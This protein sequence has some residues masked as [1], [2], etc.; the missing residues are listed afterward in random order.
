MA[1]LHEAVLGKHPATAQLAPYYPSVGGTRSVDDQIEAALKD[2]IPHLQGSMGYVIKTATVQTNE[3]GRG[4]IW[5]LPLAF[6][7]WE[8]VELLDLGAS[9]GLNLLAEQRCYQFVTA[10]GD[11][12]I[13]HLG[14]GEAE[15]LI[16]RTNGELDP[17]LTLGAN[18]QIPTVAT[19]RGVDLKPFLID[20]SFDELRLTSYVWADQTERI[21]R[22]QRALAILRKNKQAAA[23]VQL[24][25]VDLPHDLPPYLNQLPASNKPLVIFNTY[26]TQYFKDQRQALNE[27]VAL[28]AQSQNRPVLW[29]QWE[30]PLDWMETPREESEYGW[31]AF[32]ADFW[33]A[34]QHNHFLLGWVHPHGLQAR[35]LS[36]LNA[37]ADYWTN[38]SNQ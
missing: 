36:G 13:T 32:T 10:N 2:A 26:I 4:S 5:L 37:W 14:S 22:L 38:I 6:S 9:A 7:T 20:V 23:P 17:L 15:G 21:E 18:P 30:P 24:G 12:P 11:K 16:V 31:C 33:Q 29:L 27:A 19:R 25:E 1:G 3:T 8:T 34:N 28:W 35:F